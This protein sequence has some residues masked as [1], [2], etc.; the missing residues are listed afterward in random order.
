[1][2][3]PAEYSPKKSDTL[4]MYKQQP[5]LSLPKGRQ[6]QIQN[7]HASTL[8]HNG[9]GGQQKVSSKETTPVLK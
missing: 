3:K 6:Q 2:R 8:Y 7:M 5:D 4:A 1:M 9:Q